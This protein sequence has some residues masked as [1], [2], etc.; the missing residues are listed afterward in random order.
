MFQG[1]SE[2]PQSWLEVKG[3]LKEFDS[4]SFIK[5]IN[6]KGLEHLVRFSQCWWVHH[7]ACW[8]VT[9]GL[10]AKAQGLVK[11]SSAILDLVDSNQF[12]YGCVISNKIH[13]SN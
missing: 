4:V 11:V 9:I 10:N 6:Y 5:K 7:L 3:A 8:Y 1:P 2:A 13:L 12:S